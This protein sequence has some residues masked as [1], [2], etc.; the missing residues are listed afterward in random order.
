MDRPALPAEIARR[1]D[2]LAMSGWGRSFTFIQPHNLCFWVYVVFV[3]WGGLQAW[4]QLSSYGGFYGQALVSGAILIALYGLVLALVFRHIDRYEHEP[5]KLL[6]VGFIW[7]G[8]AATFAIAIHANDALSG[9]YAK[10]FGHAFVT[11]WSA[12]LSAPFVEETAK[13]AGFLLLMGLAPRRIRSVYDGLLV[14]AF[15]G[16]GFELFEDMIYALNGAVSSI[17]VSQTQSVL[18]IVLIRG[19]TGF[20]S[21]ALYTALFCAGL[22][23]LIG[24]PAQPV[25]RLRGVF[26]IVA[27]LVSHGVWDGAGAIGDGG[28]SVILILF[29]IAVAGVLI[30]IYAFRRAAPQEQRWMRAIMAPEVTNGTID[31]AELNAIAG[32]RKER[33]R[34]VHAAKGHKSHKRAKYVLRACRDLAEELSISEGKETPAVDHA[35]SELRRLRTVEVT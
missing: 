12:A 26:L 1:D 23:Y 8:L 31:R 5:Y 19:A 27:A 33:K 17:G 7:G 3:G 21:H 2:A 13:A 25:R 14:G 15:I 28:R 9:I 16:L 20:F 22:V 35:R 10:L 6:A 32:N 29:G 24:T 4:Q 18:Q 11:D 34:F 30:L